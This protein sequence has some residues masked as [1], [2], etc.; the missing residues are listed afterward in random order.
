MKHDEGSCTKG[1]AKFMKAV[2]LEEFSDHQKVEKAK[3]IMPRHHS[4]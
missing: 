3:M 4:K 2:K 1:I